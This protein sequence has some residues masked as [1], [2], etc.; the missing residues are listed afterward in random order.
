MVLEDVEFMAAPHAGWP[1]P[2]KVGPALLPRPVS[3]RG[4]LVYTLI[5]HRSAERGYPAAMNRM[6][7]TIVGVI[8]V[9]VGAIALLQYSTFGKHEF[10]DHAVR[11]DDPVR[12]IRIDSDSL[13]LD[14]RFVSSAD[15]NIVRIEGKAGTE[16]VKRIRSAR[17]EGGVLRLQ[18]KDRRWWSFNLFDFNRLNE[19][20]TVTVSLTD[21]AMAALESFR[22][23]VDSGSVRI[24]DAAVREG[25]V[26]SD[27]GSI[28]IGRMQSDA[29]TV[30]SDAGSIRLDRFEGG[31]LSLRSD[32]GSIHADAVSAGLN[33]VSGAGSIMIN[34]LNGYGEIRTDSGSVRIVKD[35]DTGLD[36]ST[37]SGSVRITVPASYR[38]SYDLD[39]DSGAIRHPDPVGASGEVIKV[40]TDSGSIRIEQQP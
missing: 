10:Y 4:M 12:E 39:S 37:D 34:H 7:R 28:R 21:E 6:A 23:N 11:L 29:L 25:V 32:S 15:E 9:A 5:N 17:A 26:E 33:V 18:F 20:Q 24:H 30:K 40:R 8:L 38:G 16:V 36:V 35:D 31:K 3:P 1:S 22:V 27:S 13:A 2:T 14:I 19:K